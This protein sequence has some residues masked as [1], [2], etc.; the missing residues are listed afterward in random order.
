MDQKIPKIRLFGVPTIPGC[1]GETRTLPT[2]ETELLAFLAL[3]RHR[4]HPRSVLAGVLW[5]DR[6]ERNALRC[7]STTVWR[8][9]R[10]MAACGLDPDT[11][12][13]SSPGGSLRFDRGGPWAL[14]VDLFE[15]AVGLL[16]RQEMPGSGDLSGAEA[17]L[18]LHTADLMEGFYHEWVV[19]ERERLRLMFI[20]GLS[21][22]MRHHREHDPPRAI[23]LG[24][25]ILRFDPLREAVHRELM[26][27]QM[28][29]GRRTLALRQFEECRQLLR[30]ELGV[31][32]MRETKA[33]H[34]QILREEIR[35]FEDPWQGGPVKA[36]PR[37]K[38]KTGDP[39]K[40]QGG[41]K[42][43]Q[44]E[45][46]TR[47]LEKA[48]HHLERARRLVRGDFPHSSWPRD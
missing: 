22:A 12:L 18:N 39:E 17:G 11:V 13:K 30:D 15:E 44:R 20:N 37:R 23:E 26:R 29:L 28:R 46:V 4:D 21:T 5:G 25:S 8:L 14:D 38:P 48:S 43:T 36:R 27:L 7:L 9:R 35:V 33:L 32:P 24:R 1:S 2:R 3:N 34:L 10:T 16:T 45:E 40:H 6:L 31:G 42:E 41:S 19:R 47:E